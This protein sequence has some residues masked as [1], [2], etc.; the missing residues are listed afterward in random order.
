MPRLLRQNNSGSF[1]SQGRRMLPLRSALVCAAALAMGWLASGVNLVEAA[2]AASSPETASSVA[3]P[4]SDVQPSSAHPLA[5]WTHV[6][7]EG[8]KYLVGSAKA[9]IDRWPSTATEPEV[10][11]VVTRAGLFGSGTEHLTLVER[12]AADAVAW[13]SFTLVPQEKARVTRVTDSRCVTSTR[14]DPLR[15]EPRADPSRWKPRSPERY[16]VGDASLPLLEPYMLLAHLDRW[17]DASSSRVAI[18]GKNKVTLARLRLG[19][20]RTGEISMRDP[21]TGKSKTIASHQRQLFLEPEQADDEA[22][23]SLIGPVVLWVDRDTGIPVEISGQHDKVGSIRL[24]LSVAWE[25]VAPRP[26]RAWPAT[27]AAESLCPPISGS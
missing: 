12:R 13:R 16:Q 26:L 14:F 8:R 7:I 27:V 20:E 25:A 22:L 15:R 17:L 2:P 3:T 23:L 9:S 24:K 5:R 11:Q 21:V 6:E 18:A 19:K 4:T 10:V 1:G